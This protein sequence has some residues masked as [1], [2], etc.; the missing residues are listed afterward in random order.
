M[1][2]HHT[3]QEVD[4][5]EVSYKNAVWAFVD[6]FALSYYEEGTLSG[7]LKVE[8]FYMAGLTKY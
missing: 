6:T 3:K 5:V 1:V 8:L 4:H 7:F 2:R